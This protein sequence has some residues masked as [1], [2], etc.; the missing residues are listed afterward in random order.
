MWQTLH[1]SQNYT[2]ALPHLPSKLHSIVEIGSRDSLDA[3]FLSNV[4]NCEVVAFEPNPSQ[5][6]ICQSN[7]DKSGSDVK[8]R[9]EALSNQTST[10]DFFAVDVG[11][12]NNV[13][14]SGLFK[15]NF[16]NRADDDPDR[17]HPPVQ[18]KV[19]VKA[20]RWDSLGLPCP[21]LVAMDCEG[22]E[23]LAL[24][25]FGTELSKVKYIVSEASQTAIGDGACTYKQLDKFLREKNFVFV[26]S[27]LYSTH[28]YKLKFILLLSSLV[29]RIR[30]PIGETQ[31]G[32]SFDVIY[33]N[34]SG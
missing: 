17:N 21:E 3:I 20:I 5:T 16:V 22:A 23:L 25:G 32:F 2:W 19:E 1:M 26:A 7:I 31:R 33:E 28:F 10:I 30:K 14:A 9:T 8:L 15:I 24:M 12:Y 4:F 13:G 29:R 27:S 11:I 6:K 18:V 34:T